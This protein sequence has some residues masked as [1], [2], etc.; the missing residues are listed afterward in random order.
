MI[1]TLFDRP[2]TFG[3]KE[4]IEAIKKVQ[5]SELYRITDEVFYEMV[6][7]E[8]PCR[9]KWNEFQGL[10][11]D[12]EK[13]FSEYHKRAFWNF[14]DRDGNKRWLKDRDINVINPFDD[15]KSLWNITD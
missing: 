15:S 12:C 13:N 11:I 7:F 9:T 4:Q 2:L 8:K 10:F 6:K 3:D 1:P 14:L 5:D